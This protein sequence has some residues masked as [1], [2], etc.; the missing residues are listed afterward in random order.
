[1]TSVFLSSARFDARLEIKFLAETGLFEG[2][3]SVFHVIDSAGDG[4]ARVKSQ[5]SEEIIYSDRH[6]EAFRRDAGLSRRQA[7]GVIA[8]LVRKYIAD[9][10]GRG[11]WRDP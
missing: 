3:A 1:M 2:Y 7:K 4:I 6:F 10:P 11:K 9:A 8:Q 5:F